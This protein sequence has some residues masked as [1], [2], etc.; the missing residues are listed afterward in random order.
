MRTAAVEVAAVI[1]VTAAAAQAA[2]RE[3]DMAVLGATTR[4]ALSQSVP[5]KKA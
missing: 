5:S 1:E 2:A 4:T 3:M